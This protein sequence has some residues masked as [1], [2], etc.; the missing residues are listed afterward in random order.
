MGECRD[1]LNRKKRG[2]PLKLENCY[3]DF[4][5]NFH[6]QGLTDPFI[7]LVSAC[8]ASATSQ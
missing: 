4:F 1:E 5:P 6:F 2:Q 3:T 7:Y 8:R